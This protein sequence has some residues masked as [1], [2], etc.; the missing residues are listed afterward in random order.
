MQD[1][2]VAPRVVG[3]YPS[4]ERVQ[5][6]WAFDEFGCVGGR[7]LLTGVNGVD[8]CCPRRPLAA[9]LLLLPWLLMQLLLV[10]L[11]L[12]LLLVVEP[13]VARLVTPFVI[14]ADAVLVAAGSTG[15]AFAVAWLTD[16]WENNG[17]CCAWRPSRRPAA[18]SPGV[19]LAFL[20]RG[21]GGVS[22]GVAI[23]AVTAAPMPGSEEE[24][25]GIGGPSAS[26]GGGADAVGECTGDPDVLAVR[27][28]AAVW[29]TFDR[30]FGGLRATAPQMGH[31]CV[32]PAHAVHKQACVL[33]VNLDP[34]RGSFAA[35]WQRLQ[36]PRAIRV[37]H[38]ACSFVEISWKRSLRTNTSMSVISP[39]SAGSGT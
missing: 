13:L 12:Q 8:G 21:N 27:G 35:S 32:T 29:K 22:G 34:L 17:G 37:F 14:A 23:F 2:V 10:L 38:T 5:V 28:A 1:G 4:Y 33:H 15:A 9:A 24:E 25:E 36:G 16:A 30:G 26:L 39:T 6:E 7:R 20:L 19:V 3:I 18:P 31:C 11:L